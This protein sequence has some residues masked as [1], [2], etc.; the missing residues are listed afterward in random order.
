MGRDC[1]GL[2]FEKVQIG[3]N[4]DTGLRGA[5]KDYGSMRCNFFL[6]FNKA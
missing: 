1:V 5:N 2:K 4:F 6:R 3:P